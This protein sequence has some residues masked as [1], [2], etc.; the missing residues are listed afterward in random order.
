MGLQTL[1][2]N[3][4]KAIGS[5]V[6]DTMANVECSDEH[7]A[8]IPGLNISDGNAT[9]PFVYT[10]SGVR[11]TG[12]VEFDSVDS[13]AEAIGH[14]AASRGDSKLLEQMISIAESDETKEYL[15]EILSELKE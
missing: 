11:I 2:N 15:S 12:Q 9:I 13:L 6:E 14:H 3:T 8:S 4:A 1:D 7:E 10:A 5:W